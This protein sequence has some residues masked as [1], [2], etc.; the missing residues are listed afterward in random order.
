MK[1]ALVVVVVLA[2]AVLSGCNNAEKCNLSKLTIKSLS[3]DGDTDG[4]LTRAIEKQLFARG[5]REDAKGIELHGW[6]KQ[7]KNEL[8]EL[9]LTVA[10]RGLNVSSYRAVTPREF[11]Y[12]NH[13]FGD[14]VSMA[15]QG[16]AKDVCEC[17]QA[18][19]EVSRK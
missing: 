12:H 18:P 9:I 19:S 6:V 1:N 4:A 16:V 10:I 7:D 17:V 15:A 13:P 14:Y 5:A 11:M 8:D 2:I 3:I